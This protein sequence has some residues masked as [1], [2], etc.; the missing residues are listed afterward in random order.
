MTKQCRGN[1]STT[2]CH[3]IDTSQRSS[4]RQSQGDLRPSL[5]LIDMHAAAPERGAVYRD[6]VTHKKT[7]EIA[8]ALLGEAK[9]ILACDGITV[10][11]LIEQGLRHVIP[12][13]VPLPVA[14]SLAVAAIRV[15][16]FQKKSMTTTVTRSVAVVLKAEAYS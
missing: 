3:G 13:F 11:N 9:K 16:R 14:Y 15:A 12:A 7:V 4:R 8:P 6:I 5:T 2:V 10:R 1:E